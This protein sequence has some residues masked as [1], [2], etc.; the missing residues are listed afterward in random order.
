MF[1]VMSFCYEKYNQ[2]S[3][4]LF[5]FEDVKKKPYS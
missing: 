1:S 5:P 2:L 3:L 4:Y